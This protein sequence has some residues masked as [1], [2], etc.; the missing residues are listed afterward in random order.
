MGEAGN[1]LLMCTL[2]GNF[3]QAG[4][5][6]LHVVKINFN[7]WLCCTKWGYTKRYIYLLIRK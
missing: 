4:M 2:F 6:K 5:V 7:H 3:N 1:I